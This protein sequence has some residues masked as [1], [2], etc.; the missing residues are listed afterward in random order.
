MRKKIVYKI[1]FLVLFDGFFGTADVDIRQDSNVGDVLS[2]K[3][4]QAHSPCNNADEITQ[5]IISDEGNN[6]RLLEAFY[7][8]N[9]AKP[10]FILVIFFT[11]GTRI[12]KEVCID[13]EPYVGIIFELNGRKN[14][15]GTMWYASNIN[16]ITSTV[17]ISELALLIPQS[18][19]GQYFKVNPIITYYTTVCLTIPY[20]TPPDGIDSDIND[21]LLPVTLTVSYSYQSTVVI[22]M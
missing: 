4:C 18:I 22:S 21:I 17:V 6:Q 20:L 14:V 7:P 2:N 13:R 15:Y 10:Q 9:K 11:N 12:D 1:Y 8:I 3:T 16:T 5:A 19:L